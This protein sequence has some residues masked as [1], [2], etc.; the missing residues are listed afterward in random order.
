[1]SVKLLVYE[2]I[3]CWY[4]LSWDEKK[5][6]LILRMHNDFLKELDEIVKNMTQAPIVK[7]MKEEFGF[8]S[9]SFDWQNGD[10]GFNG[11]FKKSKNSKKGFVD[12]F[13]KVPEVEREIKGKKCK[14]CRGTGETSYDT[15][16]LYCR[17]TGKEKE[18]VWTNAFEISASFSVILGLSFLC[19]RD[20]SSTIPQLLTVQT[21]TRKGMHGGSL[22][23][24]VSVPLTEWMKAISKEGDVEIPEAV[25]AMKTAHGTMWT[26][27]EFDRFMFVV[28]KEGAFI[29][30]CPGNACG[31]H[32]TNWSELERKRGHHFSCHNVD[33]PMQQL[34]LIVGLAALCDKARKEMKL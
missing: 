19:K 12:F 6:A 28:R 7:A 31:L 18:I 2:N 24:E 11:A 21:I 30:D 17:G 1:M 16:C 13:I 22:D 14:G 4:E 29:S 3:P 26:S 32:P 5:C 27:H 25:K 34:T 20:T 9:F 15:E 8:T 33:S 23:G 10:I